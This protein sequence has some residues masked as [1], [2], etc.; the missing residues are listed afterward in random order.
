MGRGNSRRSRTGRGTL[1]KFRAGSWDPRRGRERFGGPSLV[2]GTGRG[3]SLRSGNR[4]E[5]PCLGSKTGRRKLL[6]V[7]Y[8]SRNPRKV[9]DVRD[10]RGGL[11]RINGPSVKS[12]TGRGPSRRSE[13]C[14]GNHVEVRD[15]SGHPRRGTGPVGK[16]FLRSGTGWGTIGEVWDGLGD[17]RGGLGR[18]GEPRKG[19]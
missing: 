15:G 12:R 17:P 5:G 8:R 18:V 9:R 14:Q 13:T 4:F 16:T 1:K 6:K 2:S 11:G 10:P 19:P 3:T 7:R